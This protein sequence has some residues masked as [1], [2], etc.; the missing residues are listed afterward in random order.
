MKSYDRLLRLA[1]K[2]VRK[3]A[4]EE[5]PSKVRTKQEMH[6]D[7]FF[8]Q[9]SLA[10]YEKELANSI[11]HRGFGLSKEAKAMARENVNGFIDKVAIQLNDENWYFKYIQIGKLIG[12]DFLLARMKEPSAF[13]SRK[14]QDCEPDANALRNDLRALKS[15]AEAMEEP[16]HYE[17]DDAR[18]QFENL[19]KTP[20][21]PKYNYEDDF[22][23]IEGER[24]FRTRTGHK[25]QYMFQPS[26]RKTA[27]YLFDGDRFLSEEEWGEYGIIM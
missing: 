6:N 20:E 26:T 3:I 22:R 9:E 24:P 13:T 7:W 25:V 17:D 4:Q 10:G 8:R 16:H 5:N 23:E 27:Y 18:I 12:K 19:A 14:Y 2:F 11:G 1:N 21:S 15:I